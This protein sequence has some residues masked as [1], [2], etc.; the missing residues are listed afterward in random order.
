MHNQK[1][2]GK[3]TLGRGAALRWLAEALRGLVEARTDDGWS[4][5]EL[6]ELAGDIAADI[7]T[8]AGSK[9]STRWIVE[10]CAMAVSGFA[11]REA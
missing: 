10:P 7:E 1:E 4:G 9:N 6:A 3:I 8:V 11:I 5:D 2:S